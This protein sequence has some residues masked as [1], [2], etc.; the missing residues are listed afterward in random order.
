MIL[1]SHGL[2]EKLL[3]KEIIIHHIED[4]QIQPASIDL[5]LTDEFMIIDEHQHEII[6][7][8]TPIKY[9]EIKADT[10]VIPPKSFILAK[11]MEYLEIPL[12]HV[13]FVEGRSSIGRLGLFIQNAGWIDPGFKGTITLE[14]FN[15][16]NVPIKL[17]A[18]RRICQ[19][20]F[21]T[22]DKKLEQGYTGKYLG[23][24][25]VTGSRAHQDNEIK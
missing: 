14:L 4:H 11:T 12:D 13:A 18:G 20:V 15:A 19:I 5:R 16:C 22:M 24:I 3:N 6:D 10:I 25:S 23:Q 2:K 9:R 8:K 17:E 7:M 1:S 21:V